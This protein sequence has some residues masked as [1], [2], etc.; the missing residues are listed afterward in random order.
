MLTYN[1]ENGET[2]LAVQIQDDIAM[3]LNQCADSPVSAI[4]A[5][6]S[7]QAARVS[8]WAQLIA[9]ATVPTTTSSTN[10]TAIPTGTGGPT[11][12]ATQNQTSMFTPT[13]TPSAESSSSS[14][15]PLSRSWVIGPVAGSVLGMSTVFI[16]IFFTRRKQRREVLA[17]EEVPKP[18]SDNPDSPSA[19]SSSAAGDDIAQLHSD[20]IEPPKELPDTE[21]YEMAA[22]DPVGTELNT[23]M[24]ARPRIRLNG[25]GS[26]D[27]NDDGEEEHW[28]I[29][30]PLPLS[31][32]P[33]L[34]AATELRDERMGRSE[35]TRHQTY[36]HPSGH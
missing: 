10:A 3:F 33:A 23:P 7:S 21:V 11:A 17:V 35:S 26:V 20:T 31:P 19:R 5:N 30:S 6:Y 1:L 22:P 24:T 8:S 29:Q 14:N 28:P 12:A 25:D 16:V 18:F 36:Y 27:E 32:L 9:T 4:I 13:P 2:P 34:F 15:P